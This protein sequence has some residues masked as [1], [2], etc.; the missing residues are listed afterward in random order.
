MNNNHYGYPYVNNDD[1][2]AEAKH[3][4]FDDQH[5][6]LFEQANQHI[7][8][9]KGELDKLHQLNQ[10]AKFEQKKKVEIYDEDDDIYSD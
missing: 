6:Q 9:L 3:I 5:K 7:K 8:K 10:H 1:N 2:D 4:L